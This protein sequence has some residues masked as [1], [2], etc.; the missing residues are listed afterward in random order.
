MKLHRKI[1][2]YIVGLVVL[3]GLATETF[4]SCV[5]VQQGPPCQAFWSAHAVFIG[6]ATSVEQVPNQTQLAVG[7]YLR[8]TT[9]FSVEEA[10]KGVEGTVVVFDQNDCPYLFKEGE[11]YLVYAYYNS[12]Q[13]KLE[14]RV[15]TTRTRPLS[16]AAEDLAYI[17]SLPSAQ[18]GSRILGK[19]VQQGF[20][21]NKSEVQPLREVRVTLVSD[22]ETREVVTDGEGRYEFKGLSA[23]TYRVRVDV[24]AYLAYREQTIKATDRG[25]IVLDIFAL[26]KG[27]ITGRVLDTNGKAVHGVPVTLVSADAKREDILSLGKESS[28]GV[29]VYSNRDGTYSFSQLM[30]GRYLVVVNRRDFAGSGS[31]LVRN[32][33]TLFYPGVNDLGAATVIVLTNDQKPQEYDFVLPIQ[34]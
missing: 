19:A 9:H 26:Y 4:A 21:D 2:L 25:C 6:T 34:Q 22:D 15:G 7:P 3:S 1:S 12:Y 5:R 13:K 16:E 31:E 32:L 29:T 14:V 30:P 28:P 11:R 10:F 33:P 18:A 23:G 24:P 17:R 8:S 20:K 27:Q